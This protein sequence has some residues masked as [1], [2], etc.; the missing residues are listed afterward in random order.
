MTLGYVRNGGSG[1][2]MVVHSLC[3]HVFGLI[4]Q[5]SSIG[6]RCT[7]KGD[8]CGFLKNCLEESEFLREC[9]MNLYWILGTGHGHGKRME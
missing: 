9:D 4:A 2:S 5:W 3:S 1:A 7:G 8:I 6:H